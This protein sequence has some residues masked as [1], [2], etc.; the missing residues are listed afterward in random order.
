MIMSGSGRTSPYHSRV[1]GGPL[2]KFDMGYFFLYHHRSGIDSQ[3]HLNRGDPSKISLMSDERLLEEHKVII[4]T[5]PI[6]SKLY[7]TC[8]DR[9]VF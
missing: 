6:L 1:M 2:D 4:R 5:N 8:V 3:F 7:Q 9:N